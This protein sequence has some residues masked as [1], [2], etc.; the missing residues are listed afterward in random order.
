MQDNCVY[1]L[2]LPS[3]IVIKYGEPRNEH[4]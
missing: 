3:N 2:N 1:K 4:I